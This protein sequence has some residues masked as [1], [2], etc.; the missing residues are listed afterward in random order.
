[1]SLTDSEDDLHK[2]QVPL[3]TVQEVNSGL[4]KEYKYSW[5]KQRNRIKSFLGKDRFDEV[6]AELLAE[7]KIGISQRIPKEVEK[8]EERVFEVNEW[9]EGKSA[10]HN[11]RG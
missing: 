8:L 1:M 9:S 2:N 11:K 4:N 10:N 5:S 7:R 6:K 3:K